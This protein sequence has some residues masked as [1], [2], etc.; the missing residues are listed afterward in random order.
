MTR[1]RDSAVHTAQQTAAALLDEVLPLAR[2]G[3]DEIHYH[4]AVLEV[5]DPA[6]LLELAADPVF[7]PFLLCRFA[8][9][10]ALIDPGRAVVLAETLRRRGHT[11]KLIVS[12]S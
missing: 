11:P 7:Q 1:K 8:D 2:P 6:Q 10:I 4:A 3:Q 12:A 5:S 9:N